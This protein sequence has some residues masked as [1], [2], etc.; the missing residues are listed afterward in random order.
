MLTDAAPHVFDGSEA[1]CVVLL[2]GEADDGGELVGWR[3]TRRAHSN[4]KPHSYLCPPTPALARQQRNS[5]ELASRRI[6]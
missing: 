3:T 1:L 5:S 4:A 6:T 2:G